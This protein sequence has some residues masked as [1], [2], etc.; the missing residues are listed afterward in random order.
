V[1]AH[2]QD[3]IPIAT[4]FRYT[5]LIELPVGEEIMTV[6]CG[7]KSYWAVDT[8]SKNLV[9]IRPKGD[10]AGEHTNINL[11]S[12]SGNVY[13]FLVRE[14]S[15]TLEHADLKVFIE[16]PDVEEKANQGHPQFVRADQLEATKKELEEAQKQVKKTQADAAMRVLGEL[17]YDY[18]W[19]RNKE[20]E[21]FHV[22]AIWHDKTFTYISAQPQELPALY[23]IKDGKEMLIQIERLNGLYTVPHIMDDGILR[24][25]KAKLE[26]HRQQG[27]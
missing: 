24:L 21:T 14:V 7:D 10:Q 25:G 5:T 1:Q 2:R 23:E 12:A 4:A 19:P 26:F 3:I 8:D 13:T 20:A 16:T 6:T 22:K 17:T 27:S 11:L 9:F 18:T 15:Q